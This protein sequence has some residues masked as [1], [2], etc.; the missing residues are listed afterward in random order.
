MYT[1]SNHE[2]EAIGGGFLSL[3]SINVSPQI[4]INTITGINAGASIALLGGRSSLDQANDSKLWQGL[5]KGLF[6]TT[7]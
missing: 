6:S 7:G 1:L 3:P 4:M 2:A 5:I